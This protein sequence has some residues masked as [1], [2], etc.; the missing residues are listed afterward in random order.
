MA[1]SKPVKETLEFKAD[2]RQVLEIITHSLYSHR[3][4]FLRELISNASDALDKLRFEALTRPELRDQDGELKVRISVDKDSK[5]L[6]VSD[7][8]IGMSRSSIVDDLG[9]IAKSGTR[10]FLERLKEAKSA[11]Q[12]ELIGQFGVGFYSAF[13]VASE[14]TVRSR[15]AGESEGVEWTSRGEGEFTLS[16]VDKPDPGTEIR[17]HLRDDADEYLETHRLMGL[18]RKY[19]DFIE[20]PVVME[21][22]KEVDGEKSLVEETLN[23]GKAIWLRSPKDLSE[24][25]YA[26]FYKQL[27]RDFQEPLSTIHYSAE[28]VIEFKSLLFIPQSPP[29]DQL[30]G[31]SR[32]GLSLY[33]QRVFIMDDCQDLLPAYLRFVRGV[34]DSADLPLNVSRE[35][36]QENALVHKIR[37]NLTKRILKSLEEMKSD[38]RVKYEKFF[39]NMGPVLKEGIT[40]DFENHEAVAELLLFQSTRT[41]PGETTTLEHYL[42][43]MPEDQEAIWY[44]IGENRSQIE[45]A[46]YLESFKSKGQE[47]LLLTD[48]VDEFLVHSLPTYKEKPLRAVDREE[49]ET[50][51]ISE[52]TK[53]SYQ[54]VLEYLDSRIEEVC[55]V[56]LS[57]RLR[58]SASCL[59]A[60]EGALGSHMERLL[61]KM[62]REDEMPESKRILELNPEHAAVQAL[63]TLYESD[64][65]DERT[66]T[67]GRLLYDEAVL[68]EGS[69]P[70]DPAAFAQRINELIVGSVRESGPK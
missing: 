24:S 9:T 48:P 57:S 5:T 1:R 32:S 37:K 66:L 18:V 64:R 35:L 29:W 52:L 11:D 10:S 68:A 55:E 40:R 58:E 2:L 63:R 16:D 3:E 26:E 22:E 19:S 12:P 51:E 65:E 27:T 46:P 60:A 43:G 70:K 61:E 14:I 30:F 33:I 50:E 54:G 28:G 38:D 41:Q 56:R 8:G 47:V 67:F 20:H 4:V 25:D 39:E 59:V 23:S 15:R 62:G 21:L 42:A 44:L 6:T 36:L 17:L 31:E 69:R 13:M 49:T 34:V 45:N 7:N 53:E